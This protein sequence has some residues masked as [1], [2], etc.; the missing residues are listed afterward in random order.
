MKTN[1]LSTFAVKVK[2]KLVELN[3]TQRELANRI[4]VNENYLTDILRG[5][6]SGQKYKDAI[7][8]CLGIDEDE[9]E[10]SA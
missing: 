9:M 10:K 7:K 1:K 3:M 4:G 5:R 8:K 6:R 2:T